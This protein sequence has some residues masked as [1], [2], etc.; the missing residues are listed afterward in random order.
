[1]TVRFLTEI[2][3]GIPSSPGP[4]T[5]PCT[6]KQYTFL[7]VLVGINPAG[8]GTA[9]NLALVNVSLSLVLHEY[10]TPFLNSGIR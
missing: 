7:L 2:A 10:Q 3:Q 9:D 6:L 5:E 8:H 1:M 4:E